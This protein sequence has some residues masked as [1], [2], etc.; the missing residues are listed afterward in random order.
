M[1]CLGKGKGKYYSSESELDAS[2]STES[3][4]LTKVGASKI[5]SNY[6]YV[7]KNNLARSNFVPEFFLFTLSL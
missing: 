4:H 1:A 2:E 6:K 7:V 5:L 3:P